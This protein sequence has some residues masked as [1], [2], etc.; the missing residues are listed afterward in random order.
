MSKRHVDTSHTGRSETL[1]TK[2]PEPRS[3]AEEAKALKNSQWPRCDLLA[4]A[5][6]AKGI[7]AAE[8]L[9]FASSSRTHHVRSASL[10][11]LFKV[12][13]ARGRRL[14]ERLLTDSA[15]EVRETAANVLDVLIPERP[16]K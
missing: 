13:A 1:A 11:N 14:A 9:E 3:Y 16:K 5:L 15:Y 8:A 10:R 6:S 7:T 4:E 2:I 12:D